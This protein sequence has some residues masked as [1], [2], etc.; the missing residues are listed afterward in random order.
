MDKMTM[1]YGLEARVPFLDF[2]IIEFAA[3]L[4]ASLK[5]RGFR[6]KALVK[7]VARRWIPNE[8][9]DRPKSGFGVPL[10]SWF[11]DGE[12]LGR[13]ATGSESEAARGA[14]AIGLPKQRADRIED[15]E[16]TWSSVVLGLWLKDFRLPVPPP[17]AAPSL[18]SAT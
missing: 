5:M 7:N 9:I 10:G 11:R 16:Q 18:S 4:P 14:V 3:S 8:I 12:S 15:P 17:R 6:T 2:R 1:A 13:F